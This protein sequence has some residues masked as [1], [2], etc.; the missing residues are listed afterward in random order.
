MVVAPSSS[1]ARYAAAL[2]GQ[3]ALV[4][5]SGSEPET[6]VATSSGGAGQ[7]RAGAGQSGSSGGG[8]GATGGAAA[9]SQGSSGGSSGAGGAQGGRSSAGAGSSGTGALAGAGGSEPLSFE[10]DI[11]PM[12][13]ALRDPVFVYHDGTKYESCVTTGVCH[14]GQNPGAGLRMPDAKT[15]YG[16]L[17][18]QPS[19]SDLCAGTIRVVARNPDES[20]LIL[21]YEGRLRDDLDWVSDT[22][23][24]RVRRWIDDGALP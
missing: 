14:G 3:L 16:M 11:Y 10:A 23:I 21:F 17:L 24:D 13:A 12:F 9:G 22:E 6:A 20:C 15:A 4:A 19:A 2:A 18:D 7:P 5:C 1:R 8:S